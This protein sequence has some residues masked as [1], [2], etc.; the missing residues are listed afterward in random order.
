MR[1]NTMM[2]DIALMMPVGGARMQAVLPYAALAQSRGGRTLWL[3]QVLSG[4]TH[5]PFIH[6]AAAGF[7]VPAGIGVSLMPLRHPY[8]AA[9]QAQSVAA[10]TGHPVVAG[11]GPGSVSFQKRLLGAPYRSQ[12]GAVREYVSILK[13]LLDGGEVAVT[14]E[15]FSFHGRLPKVT[16]PRVEVGLGVLRPGMARLAGEVADVAITWLA[17]AAYIRDVIL[18]ALREGAATRGRAV[19]RVVAMV[20][21]ALERAG[22]AAEELVLAGN[23]AHLG[24][25]HYR[26]MLRQAG[27]DTDVDSDPVK[28]ARALVDGGAFLYGDAAE[29][30]DRVTEYAAAGADEVV[31]SAG[32]VVALEGP[33]AGLSEAQALL[34]ALGHPAV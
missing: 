1:R 4:D 32:G 12:L 27:M 23:R 13:G 17:P 7:P 3:G 21:A 28:A 33:R 10:A 25:P 19:P 29:L 20:P 11:Y 22:R 18:P 5:H 6:A 16:R 15:Y 9:V 8:D 34:A 30:K 2:P 26:D 31:V 24:L 14:G